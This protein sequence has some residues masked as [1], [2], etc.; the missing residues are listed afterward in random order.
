[1]K[2]P[3]EEGELVVDQQLLMSFT[4]GKYKDVVLY[5]VAPIEVCHILLGTPWKLKKNYHHK[6]T[7]KIS[8]V[9]EGHKIKLAPLSHKEV[10]EDQ[11]KLKKKIEQER[12]K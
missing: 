9:H 3:C 7:N 11:I 8:F 1:L 6:R 12:K 2:F 10:I 5:D 4:I